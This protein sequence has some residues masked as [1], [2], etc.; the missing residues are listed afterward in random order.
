MQKSIL[1]NYKRYKGAS[2]QDFYCLF[3][4]YL[5]RYATE[6]SDNF[7]QKQ[8]ENK[9]SEKNKNKINRKMYLLI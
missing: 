5:I 4:Y 8:N 3:N 9:T 7:K 2:T 6:C 1:S